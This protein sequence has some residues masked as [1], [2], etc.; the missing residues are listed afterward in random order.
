MFRSGRYSNANV[1]VKLPVRKR[2]MPWPHKNSDGV[3]P[4][5]ETQPWNGFSSILDENIALMKKVYGNAPVVA[6]KDL[7]AYY[8]EINFN[9]KGAS[10]LSA[11]DKQKM[12]NEM[13][14]YG[15]LPP[16]WGYKEDPIL[17]PAS[18]KKQSMWTEVSDG[19]VSAYDSPVQIKA[20]HQTI[21]TTM[22]G[23]PSNK[24]KVGA[25]WALDPTHDYTESE[26]REKLQRSFKKM[27]DLIINELKEN[28]K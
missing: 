6:H 19:P 14:K 12:L 11:I 28:K 24:Q 21:Y 5:Q 15:I 27:E 9:I 8:N 4:K 7:Q 23:L 16:D 13:K 2:Y 26:I 17:I 22:P 1:P 10:H 25:S 18:K 20:I 3:I